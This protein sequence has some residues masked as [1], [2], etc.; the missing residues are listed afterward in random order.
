MSTYREPS[1]SELKQLLTNAKTIAVVGASS[2]ASRPSYGIFGKLVRVGYHTIPVNPSETEVHG[3]KA[4]ASLAA[5]E[6]P[7]D[8]VNV[9][10]RPEFTPDV[11]RAAVAAKAKAIWLQSG[12]YNEEAARIA[13]E[14]GLMV[15]MDRCIGVDHALLQIPSKK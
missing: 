6:E 11:A 9:F 10:R 14:A 13:S 7:I 8:I 3:Q 4:V 1:T 15:V 2:D 5:I 12:I